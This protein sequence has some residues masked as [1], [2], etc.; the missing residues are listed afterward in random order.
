MEGKPLV[1]VL[2][3]SITGS[4]PSSSKQLIGHSAPIFAVSFS[5]STS[6][7]ETA[8]AST[9]STAPKYLLSSSGD[10]SVRLWSLETFTCLV[11]FKGHDS[12]VWDVQ[13]G[14]FGHY[15]VTCGLDKTARLWS[16]DHISYLRMFAGHDKDVDVI[17]WHPNNQYVFTGSSDRT[18]R[19]W[20]ITTGACVRLFTGHT[21]NITSLQCAP[22]GKMLAS[23]DD[24]GG[25]FVWD[26]ANGRM[27]K[28]LRGHGKGGIWSLSWSVESTVLVSGGADGTVRVWDIHLPSDAGAAQGKVVAEGGQAS[29]VKVDVGAGG[30]SVS[31]TATTGVTGTTTSVVGGKKKG[32]DVVISPEQISAFPTKKTPVYKVKFTRM[33]LVIAG[34]CYL[35]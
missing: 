35:P 4:R 31:A 18:V 30:S 11:V 32:K 12:P 2:P 28:R 16:Q 27:F 1:S 9:P 7:P 22:D 13:W 10:K 23:A 5:P 26:L 21:G 34:G 3:Q 25:I 20:I 33:N 15:F 14:P 29:S 8:D 24:Q 6:A 19:M 17:G